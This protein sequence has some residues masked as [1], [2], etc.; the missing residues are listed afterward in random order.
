MC[1]FVSI[2]LLVSECDCVGYMFVYLR[3]RVVVEGGQTSGFPP[4]CIGQ[5]YR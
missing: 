1:M 3:Q 4:V 2:T 5:K